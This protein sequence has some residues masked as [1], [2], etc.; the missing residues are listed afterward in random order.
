LQNTLVRAV[1]WSDGTTIS[2]EDTQAAILPALVRGS[3]AGV[4]DRPLGGGFEIETVLGRVARHYMERAL[5]E[6]NGNKSRAAEL[7]GLNSYQTFTNWMKRY[8][9]EQ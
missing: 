9:V 3:D 4:L 8:H 2:R 6:A 1:T 5:R 7:V